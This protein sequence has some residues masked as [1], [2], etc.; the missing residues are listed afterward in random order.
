MTEISKFKKIGF[1]VSLLILNTAA[2]F[3]FLSDTEKISII[4]FAVVL[5]IVYVF[6]YLN[7]CR[8]K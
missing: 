2:L 4:Y 7:H 1:L 8:S 6:M 5:T 3:V